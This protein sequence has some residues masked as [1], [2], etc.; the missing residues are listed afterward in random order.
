MHTL[1]EIFEDIWQRLEKGAKSHSS[2]FHYMQVATVDFQ[3]KPKVRTVVLRGATRETCELQFN[4]DGR[5]KKC[6]EI[7]KNNFVEV[8]LYDGEAHTQVRISGTA[9]LEKNTEKAKKLWDK[10]RVDSKKCYCAAV[11]SGNLLEKEGDA[12]EDFKP[13]EAE[14]GFE[15][16]VN[17]YLKIEKIDWL[18]L[19]HS[20][21]RRAI[22]CKVESGW[23]SSWAVP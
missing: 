20:G 13:E 14:A 6:D 19:A 17:C 16:F 5:A 21:H 8:C 11:P 15:N 22:F 18:L 12:L 4:T 9:V 10:M 1:E 2:A 23:E 7:L 3:N